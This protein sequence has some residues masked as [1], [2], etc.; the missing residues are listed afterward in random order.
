MMK[1]STM[2]QDPIVATGTPLPDYAD[3]DNF[4]VSSILTTGW[5]RLSKE[6]GMKRIRNLYVSYHHQSEIGPLVANGLRVQYRIDPPHPEEI[7]P[8]TG[9]PVGWIDAGWLPDVDE[10]T[11][12]KL[13]VGKRGYG[14]MVQLT[15][16]SYSR[17]TRFF[18]IGALS[19]DQDR[20]KVT[21]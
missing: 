10:L 11:R 8:V 17:T 4:P 5:K 12:K 19:T 13:P 21:T 7:D 14:I 1:V 20:G 3:G 2:F 15:G 16:S 6:E 18:S 9:D